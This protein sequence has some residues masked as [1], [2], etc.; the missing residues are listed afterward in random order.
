MDRPGMMLLALSFM[1]T[2]CIMVVCGVI[3]EAVAEGV[4]DLPEIEVISELS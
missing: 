2:G 3:R 1:L 4:E